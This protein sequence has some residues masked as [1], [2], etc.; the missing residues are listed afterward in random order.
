MLD[1]ILST[2][3]SASRIGYRKCTI[4]RFSAPS[5]ESS[6]ISPF[7]VSVALCLEWFHQSSTVQPLIADPCSRPPCFWP[8]V[9]RT[10]QLPRMPHLLSCRGRRHREN[11]H[12]PLLV[13][14]RVTYPQNK[15]FELASRPMVGLPYIK[16]HSAPVRACLPCLAFNIYRSEPFRRA[17]LGA[18]YPANKAILNTVMPPLRK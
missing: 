13:N 3:N 9:P 2:A 17:R 1:S 16:H 7:T 18:C 15:D 14:C 4:N 5:A 10:P 11:A 6:E 12:G 8:C